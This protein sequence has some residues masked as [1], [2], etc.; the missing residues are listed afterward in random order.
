MLNQPSPKK[1]LSNFLLVSLSRRFFFFAEITFK[2]MTAV[3]KLERMHLSGSLQPSTIS[4][5]KKP[6]FYSSQ[7]DFQAH[8]RQFIFFVVRFCW[9][10]TTAWDV[11]N[12]TCKHQILGDSK[13]PFDSPVGGHFKLW[14]AHLIIPKMSQSQNCQVLNSLCVKIRWPSNYISFLPTPK[15]LL[16]TISVR[17]SGWIGGFSSTLSLGSPQILLWRPSAM[18]VRRRLEDLDF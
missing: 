6:S 4:S 12:T 7:L 10:K 11:W 14:K 3:C 1:H 16:L 18:M 13:C 2:H 15:K 9:Q 17:D 5:F 8:L